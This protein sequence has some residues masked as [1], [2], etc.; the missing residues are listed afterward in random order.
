M[1]TVPGRDRLGVVLIHGFNS[2]PAMWQGFES[3]I[4]EDSDL[5]FVVPLPFS[6]ATRLWQ[7][8]P[9][10]RIPTLDTVADSLKEYLDTEAQGLP[11]L[12]LVAH[13][14]GG[15]VGQRL[16][17]R[18]LAEGRG[19]DLG[20]IRRVVLFA[21][22]ND[23]TQL[24]LTLRRGLLRRNPQERQLRP[25]D[26]QINDTK[27]VVLRD[28]VHAREITA[29]T[30]PIPFSVYAGESDDVVPAASARSVFP[31]AGA[32]PGDHF[33]IVR[34]D[35]RSHRSFTTLKRLILAAADGDPPDAGEE[36]A[37]ERGDGALG[38]TPVER[39]GRPIEMFTNPFALE[40]HHALDVGEHAHELGVL[41]HYVERAHDRRLAD[42]VGR[43]AAGQSAIA[44]LVGGSSTGKTRACWEAVKQLPAGWLLWH[45]IAPGRPEAA[46]ASLP[47]IGPRTVV[48]LN[49]IHHYLLPAAFAEPIS[50]GLRTLLSDPDRGPVLV[51][52]TTWE[53]HWGT[54]TQAS[55]TAGHPYAQARELLAGCDIGVPEAFTS[56]VDLSNARQAATVDPR[57]AAALATA[58]DHEYSQYLAGAPAL[59]DRYRNAPAPAKALLHAAMDARR[60]GHSL[61]L[62]LPLLVTAVEEGYLTDSQFQ[63][64]RAGWIEDALAYLGEP[65]HGESRPLSLVTPRRGQ[66]TSVSPGYRLADYLDEFGSR[67]R[68]TTAVPATLW[69][70]LII[71]AAPDDLAA[72]ARSAHDRGLMRLALRLYAAA[73]QKGHVESIERA[74][75]M[76][77][78]GM[79]RPEDALNWLRKYIPN[80]PDTLFQA[81]KRV[82]HTGSWEEA[83]ELYRRAAQ[84]G[85]VHIIEAVAD[86]IGTHW[87]HGAHVAVRRNE[88]LTLLQQAIELGSDR[89]RKEC[90]LLLWQMGRR[91]EAIDLYRQAAQNGRTDL[92]PD[93]VW[94][95]EA[96]GLFD[97][98]I[99]WLR[100]QADEGK[101]EAVVRTA[102]VLF[103]AGRDMEAVDWL[104]E[105]IDRA[106]KDAVR[107]TA[108]LLS[109]T[110]HTDEAVSWFE[111]SIELGDH[112]SL[113]PPAV[114]LEHAGRVDDALNW[115]RRIA[116]S[117]DSQRLKAEA[118]D[119]T[120]A[121]LQR[122]WEEDRVMTW[123]RSTAQ[124]G[125][126]EAILR[127]AV[128]LRRSGDTTEALGW[129][130]RA[131]E[132]GNGDAMLE[133]GELVEKTSGRE[134]ALGWYERAAAAG[135]SFGLWRAFNR[136]RETDRIEQALTLGQRAVDAGY[137]GARSMVAEMLWESGRKQEAW[138]WYER[139]T[140][141]WYGVQNAAKMLQADGRIEE[142]V[143]WLQKHELHNE[144]KS[145]MKSQAYNLR[146]AGLIDE[147]RQWYERASAS[148][149]GIALGDAADMMT[150]SGEAEEV[151]DWL[152][153]RVG[154]G[155][156]H[157]PRFLASTLKDMGRIEEALEWCR[158]DADNRVGDAA[159]A[160]AG[161]L[162]EAGRIE[163]AVA[164]L[165]EYAPDLADNGH[166]S[167]A[168]RVAAHLL[169]QAGQS[170][171]AKQLEQYG[172]ELDGSI[173]E[174][175][176]TE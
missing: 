92:L 53:D 36:S 69:N 14:Q 137:P 93:G 146:K 5:G 143:D 169:R 139:A 22:P 44:V 25:L 116:G 174:A 4:A 88:V 26:E 16:L 164:W 103:E 60:L 126:I 24:A 123:L 13:S 11:R 74:F 128:L 153:N 109:R 112:Q 122:R 72:V 68:R 157:A 87:P 40:V 1:Q 96:V 81:A 108:A 150:E 115:L 75:S 8:H 119:L 105:R 23:G 21:C 63:R 129:Y 154:A 98:A 56:R 168:A 118:M 48:W 124:D 173:A 46:L 51:L 66:R 156:T 90:G 71:H 12:M 39:P 170:Q 58:Q 151:V 142:A 30:C 33:G 97:E 29:R 104:G 171:K 120:V 114:M 110:A 2:S 175:W 149:D 165:Q 91:D 79:H 34:P 42:V 57:W 38:A 106:D 64:L 62:P 86:W 101:A 54:L 27:R 84:D 111:R 32:L 148:G 18:M 159:I 134:E 41:P 83:E 67:E 65:V 10:R 141:E 47:L 7:P 152:R 100:K 6:Y 144:A 78:Q 131:A 132:A 70:S 121:M 76:L 135:N 95:L 20:R 61:V 130:R 28:V 82:E 160:G 45:P 158:R 166:D 43:A 145:M 37:Q 133:A 35:S 163:E 9:L 147:A 140:V 55:P 52:G 125:D 15:L 127:L 167:R 50:S 99:D 73:V 3:L 102:A 17:V 162:S 117:S 77:S 107:A 89:A 59:L 155:D 172:W 49:D 176:Q 94:M 161:I 19:A 138:I 136:Y 31:D 80:S 113:R 85:D